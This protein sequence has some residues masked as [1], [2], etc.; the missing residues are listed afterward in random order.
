MPILAL[1]LPRSR[2]GEAP[3]SV[4]NGLL[5]PR[6]DGEPDQGVPAR[7]VR[8]PR[9]GGNHAG[10]P[11]PL[12]KAALRPPGCRRAGVNAHH[13]DRP[14]QDAAT[15]THQLSPGGGRQ[16]AP[17]QRPSLCSLHYGH[18]RVRDCRAPQGGG[19][20]C[21]CGR[22][23]AGGMPCGVASAR[24][25]SV[26]AGSATIC[27]PAAHSR[28]LRLKFAGQ[29]RKHRVMPQFVVVVQVLVAAGN[30]SRRVLA[31]RRHAASPWCRPSVPPTR[32]R[33]CR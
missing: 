21:A 20:M 26:P 14:R 30:P 19:A 27:P 6:R 16:T 32:P 28:A 3:A 9:L 10:Q 13:P 18:H 1:W 23:Q 4:R 17:G 5:R 7:P 31:R 15:G 22:A 2:G 11:T 8:R 24:R 33:G 29:H 25:G 12:V